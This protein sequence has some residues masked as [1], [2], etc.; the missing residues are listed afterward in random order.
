MILTY[1]IPV[2]V[3]INRAE[4]GTTIGDLIEELVETVDESM[5][6]LIFVFITLIPVINVIPFLASMLICL[7]IKVK[8]IRV[9]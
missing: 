8:D 1:V 3:T 4:E 9:K 2:W 7:Y 5:P 6:F